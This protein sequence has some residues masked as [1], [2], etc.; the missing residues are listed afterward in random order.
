VRIEHLQKTIDAAQYGEYA[1]HPALGAADYKLVCHLPSGRSVYTF[2]MCPGGS[3][4]N[5]AAIANTVVTNGMS[6]HARDGKNANSALLVG[7]NPEDFP[8]DDALSGFEFQRR[9]EQAAFTLAGGDYKAPAQTV[10][11][12]LA[13]K[14][15]SPAATVKPSLR[16][17]VSFCDIRKCLPDFITDSLAEAIVLF[18]Q[19]LKGFDDP[20]ALLIAPETR[21]SSPVRLFRDENYQTVKGLFPCGEGPGYAGGIMSAACDGIRAAEALIKNL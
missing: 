5:S 13:Q 18:G 1:G 4:V 6:L 9:I 2:C 8:G 20:D 19:K 15:G 16:P 12:F 3:V 17:G 14:T 7:V 21:S 11:D 10:G